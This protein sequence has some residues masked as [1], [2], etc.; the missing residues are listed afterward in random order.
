MI[1]YFKILQLEESR[2]VIYFE[3]LDTYKEE[4]GCH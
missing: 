4:V 3:M 1:E 2:Y